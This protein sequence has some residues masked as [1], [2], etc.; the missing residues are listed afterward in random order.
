MVTEYIGGSDDVKYPVDA[1]DYILVVFN[2]DGGFTAEV[3]SFSIES[4][5]S[6]VGLSDADAYDVGRSVTEAVGQLTGYSQAREV[7][8]GLFGG[9]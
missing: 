3:H 8:Q 4:S 1:K 5:E 7:L 9:E 6:F 2:E